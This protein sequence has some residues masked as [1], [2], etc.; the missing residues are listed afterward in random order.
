MI[1]QVEAALNLYCASL[2]V[3]PSHI[4][5]C[6]NYSDRTGILLDIAGADMKIFID[7]K[8]LKLG[9][10]LDIVQ[11]KTSRYL[12]AVPVVDGKWKSWALLTQRIIETTKLGGIL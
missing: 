8:H 6:R 3:D 4:E 2:G 10:Q 12:W 9:I 5:I 1:P 11:G 7:Y